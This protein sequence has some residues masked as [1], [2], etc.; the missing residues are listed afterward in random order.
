[1]WFYIFSRL[2]DWGW[3]LLSLARV[4]EHDINH[5]FKGLYLLNIIL[6]W[7]LGMANTY[8]CLA[9][10][11][12]PPTPGPRAH[13]GGG[14]NMPLEEDLALCFYFDYAMQKNSSLTFSSIVIIFK[15]LLW[16]IITL[17]VMSPDIEMLNKLFDILNISVIKSWI[18][19]HLKSCCC[20]IEESIIVEKI[21]SGLLQMDVNLLRLQNMRLTW[22]ERKLTY[23][24]CQRTWRL[25]H[26]C[27]PRT[28]FPQ[29]TMEK[30]LQNIFWI[31]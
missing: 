11:F 1:M 26:I 8:P 19:W 3:P 2:A 20:R 4:I 31:W 27:D 16:T 30:Y 7:K 24:I 6:T 13:K 18:W 17:S 14:I 25:R 9:W 28:A 23:F 12:P 29:S 15:T 21:S 22:D 10:L 5:C